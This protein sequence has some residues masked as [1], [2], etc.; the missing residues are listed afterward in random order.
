MDDAGEY[1][2]SLND[3]ENLGDVVLLSGQLA[4]R[5]LIPAS[6]LYDEIPL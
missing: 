2:G 6:A 1:S 3:F 4:Y 5:S